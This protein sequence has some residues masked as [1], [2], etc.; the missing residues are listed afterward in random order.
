MA[1]PKHSIKNER[2]TLSTIARFENGTKE[3][4]RNFAEEV[5]EYPCSSQYVKHVAASRFGHNV[6]EGVFPDVARTTQKR[7]CSQ[8]RRPA[9]VFGLK[10]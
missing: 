3:S 7:R 4:H 8:S 10:G 9:S 2:T 6:G 5:S 1:D